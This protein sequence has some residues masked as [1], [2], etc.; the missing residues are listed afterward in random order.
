MNNKCNLR[1]LIYYCFGL[2]LCML[3]LPALAIVIGSKT[4]ITEPTTFS[5]TELDMTHGSFIVRNG[6]SLTIQNCKIDGVISA[7]NPFLISVEL[8]EVNLLKNEV[9]ISTSGIDPTPKTEA[10]QYVIRMGRSTGHISGNSFFIDQPFTAGLLT[11][12]LILPAKNVRVIN[13]VFQNFHGV[14]YLLNSSN[15]IVD[16]NEFKLN[17]GGNIV[18]VGDKSHITNNSIYFSGRNQ[19]GNAMDIV[20][21]ED[22]TI[23]KNNIFSPTSLGIAIT[24]SRNILLDNNVITGGIT[25]AIKLL[26]N[27]EL[28]DPHN[29]TGRIVAKLNKKTIA[30]LGTQDIT[31]RNNFM[32]QNRY[33]LAATDVTNLAVV[34][35]YFSQRFVDAAARKFWTDN[36][37]LLQNVTGLTWDSNFYKEAFTQ[38]NGGDNSMTEIVPFPESGG[39]VL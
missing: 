30:Q 20:A 7:D 8:G 19:L 38:V 2:F 22:V 12:S 14:L 32:A 16:G 36:N 21:S 24:L 27:A 10:S 39:V 17:S 15:T 23:A 13:N 1:K 28:K 31:I 37:V 4:I 33:G 11:T 6:A 35:N 29:F 9:S 3:S 26:S 18:L 5:N 25:Y 34:N